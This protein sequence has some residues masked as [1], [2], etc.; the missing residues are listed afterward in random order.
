MRKE[1][2][3]AQL[4]ADLAQQVSSMITMTASSIAAYSGIPFG[5]LAIAAGVIA[6]FFGLFQTMRSRSEQLKAAFM[7]GPLDQF[8]SGPSDRNGLPGYTVVDQFGNPK[9]KMNGGEFVMDSESASKYRPILESMINKTYHLDYGRLAAQE[10]SVIQQEQISVESESQTIDYDRMEQMYRNVSNE[11]TQADQAFWKNKPDFVST[12][13]GY[14][15]ITQNGA[16]RQRFITNK[17]GMTRSK[18]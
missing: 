1:A 2:L 4:N 9:M 12:P 7:G 15:K 16:K 13:D 8:L 3:K 11:R 18:N 5:G 17:N 14:M 6:G 10:I